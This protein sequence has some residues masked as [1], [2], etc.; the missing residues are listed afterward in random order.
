MKISVKLEYQSVEIVTPKSSICYL[1]KV[2][3]TG[4]KYKP[5]YYIHFMNGSMREI[6]KENYEK[7]EKEMES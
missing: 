2:E 5:S 7:L 4:L 6:T 1:D 3:A